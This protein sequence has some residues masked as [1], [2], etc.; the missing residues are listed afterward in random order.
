MY[1]AQRP[2]ADFYAPI[3]VDVVVITEIE[4]TSKT[5]IAFLK[6]GN[7]FN[8]KGYELIPAATSFP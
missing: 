8:K 2:D 1:G 4:T 3:A 6:S 5:P 7:N